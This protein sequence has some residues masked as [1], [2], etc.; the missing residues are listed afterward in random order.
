MITLILIIDLL[1]LQT[2]SPTCK[3]YFIY[4]DVNSYTV[5]FNHNSRD[6]NFGGFFEQM[7]TKD[8]NVHVIFCISTKISFHKNTVFPHPTRN[9]HKF[10]FYYIFHGVTYILVQKKLR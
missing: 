10:L 3:Y 1:S 6:I 7:Q 5:G 4:F 8:S 9:N 2:D